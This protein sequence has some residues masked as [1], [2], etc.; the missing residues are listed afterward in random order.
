[1]T[2]TKF[3]CYYIMH[4]TSAEST[5]DHQEQIHMVFANHSKEGVIYPLSVKVIAQPEK[6]N[7]VLKKLHMHDKYSTQLIEDTQLLCKDDKVVIPTILQ[8]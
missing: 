6:Y 4:A 1:M 3:W 2:F 7:A 5:L 8:N